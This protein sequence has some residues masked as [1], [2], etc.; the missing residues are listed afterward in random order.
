M[1]PNYFT[2]MKIPML[3]GRD[4]DGH[5]TADSPFVVIISEAMA[6]QFFPSEDPVGQQLRFDF[7]P[8]ERP[9]QSSELWATR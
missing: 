8:N 3:Q 5:D 4:F 9:R 2:V 1:T 7:V 6:R